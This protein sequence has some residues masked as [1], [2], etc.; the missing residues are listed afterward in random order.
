MTRDA[1]LL[2]ALA[3]AATLLPFQALADDS[4]PLPGVK[5]PEPIVQAPQPEPDEQPGTGDTFK[6]GDFDVKVSGS[7][8]V[9]IGF[10]KVKPPR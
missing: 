6:V 9:D 8:T 2:S 4:Q 7:V 5:Q 10:G 3:V 1:R